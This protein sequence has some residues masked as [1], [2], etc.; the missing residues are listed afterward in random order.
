[1]DLANYQKEVTKYLGKKVNVIVDRPVG[2][3][4]HSYVYP[5]NYG[6]IVELIAP[7]GECQDAYLLGC[8]EPLKEAQGT[9]IAI[10]RREDDN[11]DKLVVALN[12]DYTDE[13]IE[14]EVH[15]QERFF[16][17]KIVR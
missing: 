10:I 5:I 14:N 7:D 17:H 4:H 16:K 12:G 11:E 6:Y 15:F 9:V 8:K 3:R 2:Y 13:E 1:M